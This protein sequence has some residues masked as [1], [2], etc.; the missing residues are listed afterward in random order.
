MRKRETFNKEYVSLSIAALN[1]DQRNFMAILIYQ[2]I[3][4]T[5]I[6]LP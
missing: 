4:M 5:E 2:Q 3:Q 1:L 6:Y